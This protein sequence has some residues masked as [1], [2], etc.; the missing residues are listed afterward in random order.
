MFTL[1][2]RKRVSKWKELVL[3]IKV[4]EN[5]ASLSEGEEKIRRLIKVTVKKI[6][7][8]PSGKPSSSNDG[9]EF[10]FV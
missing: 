10:Y 9:K 5:K 4:K 3:R 7:Y 8:Y 6:L 2:S 1:S